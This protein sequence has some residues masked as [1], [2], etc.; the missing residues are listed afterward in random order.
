M[1]TETTSPT[2]RRRNRYRN[3][4]FAS[5]SGCRENSDNWDA[6]CH[7]YITCTISK[8]LDRASLRPIPR[9]LREETHTRTAI[10]SGT[11]YCNMKLHAWVTRTP[12]QR[13]SKSTLTKISFGTVPRT[14]PSITSRSGNCRLSHGG[15][16]VFSSITIPLQA[17]AGGARR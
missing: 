14:L 16:G 1:A 10:H 2:S 11:T 17:S 3:T 5:L 12:P 7:L 15:R 8:G 13:Q 4:S 9:E 6:H